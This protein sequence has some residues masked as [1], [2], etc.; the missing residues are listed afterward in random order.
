MKLERVKGMRDFSSEDMI[1]RN[2]VL[3]T[4]RK[5]FE[6]FGFEPLETP[7]LE[8]WSTLSAK[9]AGGS[10]ILNETYVF[11]DKGNRDVA[12]RYDLTVPLARFIAMNPNL[13]LPFKRYQIDRVWRYSDVAKGRLREFLQADIDTIGSDSMLADAEVISCAIFILKKLKFR[14]FS[15]RLN[16]RKILSAIIKFS[17]VNEDKEIEV[18]RVIDK[19]DKIG[20]ECVRDEL[21]K[22]ISSEK[23]ERIFDILDICGEPE[24]ILQCAEELVG[25]S[26][27]G[28]EG[29]SELKK[30]L[31]YLNKFGN[32]SEVKI[33]LSLARGL[34]YYT[35]PIFE[36]SATENIGSIAGGGRYDK[37]IGIFLGREIPATGISLGIERIIEIIKERKIFSFEKTNT[38]VFVAS[39]N[40]TLF[41]ETL[42]IANELREKDIPT[43]ID[44]R[45]RNLSKQLEFASSIGIPIVL[46]V[47]QKELREGKVTLRNMKTGEQKTVEIEKIL[48]EL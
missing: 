9:G 43:T 22:I 6:I 46:I 14:E 8:Y 27:E 31:S 21:S 36:I 45:N 25:E 24:K 5:G 11:K 39:T 16:N 17:G 34:D 47:G 30:L 33:D 38:K 41:E 19:L 26:P 44:L 1:L 28:K 2:F 18:L 40:E 10:E 48:E 15:V 7:A 32:Y 13:P 4:I 12:L 29:I 35:G 20:K 23:I 42:K 3:N 37:M